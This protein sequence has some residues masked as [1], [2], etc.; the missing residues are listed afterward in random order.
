M[1]NN[2]RNYSKQASNPSPQSTNVNPGDDAAQGT[3][4]S[5]E[6]VCPA[7]QGRGKK[8]NGSACPNCAGSGKIVEGIGGG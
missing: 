4:G 1:Q 6:D 2:S 7:C 5:G 8:G 3:P